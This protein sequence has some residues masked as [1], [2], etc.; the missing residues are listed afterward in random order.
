MKFYYIVYTTIVTFQG[1]IV[2]TIVLCEIIIETRITILKYGSEVSIVI[3]IP[4]KSL[5][6]SDLNAYKHNE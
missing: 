3:L 4:K 2:I 6:I 5:V 1:M